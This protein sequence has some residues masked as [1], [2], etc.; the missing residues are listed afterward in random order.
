[1]AALTA[2]VTLLVAAACGT[3]LSSP[4]GSCVTAPAPDPLC[5]VV[6]DGGP[7]D[8]G[9]VGYSCTGTARPDDHASYVEGTPGGVLCANKGA[10]DAGSQT[11][12]CTDF[13]TPCA[14]NPVAI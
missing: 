4:T 11:Y 13:G 5:E 10:A 6:V 14:Y 3:D 7:S 1:V 2:S 9:L 8:I 12:C